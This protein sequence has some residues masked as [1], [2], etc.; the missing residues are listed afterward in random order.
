MPN[1]APRLKT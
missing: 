1:T